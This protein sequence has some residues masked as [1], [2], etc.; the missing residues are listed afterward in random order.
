MVDVLCTL[1]I[2]PRDRGDLYTN[3]DYKDKGRRN[4]RHG[5]KDWYKRGRDRMY[6]GKDFDRRDRRDRMEKLDKR[7]KRGDMFKG[8]GK[9]DW[10]G[11]GH[12]GK[13]DKK[14]GRG[15]GKGGGRGRGG[16]RGGKRG[17]GGMDKRSLRGEYAE[18]AEEE[19]FEE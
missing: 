17:G 6:R 2:K 14:G 11:K 15:G 12:G 7:F 10:G 16:K 9:G 3:V 19:G 13:F 1:P 4:Y 5:M 8:R 18:K